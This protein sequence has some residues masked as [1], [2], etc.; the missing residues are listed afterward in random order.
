MSVMNENQNQ[1]QN[2]NQDQK[3]GENSRLSRG[4]DRMNSALFCVILLIVAVIAMAVFGQ[5]VTRSINKRPGK[6][7]GV[8][9]NSGT[10]TG[11][12]QLEAGPDTEAVDM[13]TEAATEEVQEAFT[14]EQIPNI[15]ALDTESHAWGQG[16][17]YD[18]YN[19]PVS[20]VQYQETY[21][22]YNANFI[23]EN[24][25]V[26]YLTFD[27]GYE[28]GCTPK[29][30]D[31]LKEKGVHGVFF[32]TQP[33]AEENPELVQRMINE[34]HT[35]GNHSVTH[36]SK[37]LPSETIEEQQNEVM[38]C[39]QYVLEHFGYTMHLFRYPTGAFSEQSLAIV[40]NCN[41]K[42]VFWS[43]AY[44]DYDVNNQPDQA[45]SLQKLTDRMHPGA[46][47][48]LHAESET[49]AAI[50]GDFIDAARAAGYSLEMFD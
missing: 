15:E 14:A 50:L 17:Q 27:E 25:P 31:T 49:N 33:Y 32:V 2:L 40:N 26:I 7:T 8:A 18:E 21:G 1:D 13:G 42:S 24:K 19:R 10:E 23:G 12:E 37:G 29:I 45:Q 16:V 48:L 9:Q 11:T 3:Q 36:P 35:V 39:H 28:Y 34:G 20:A 41:Y 22:R 43:F 44:L 30:L 6:N 46:I 5:V 47:Y 4:L 38:G